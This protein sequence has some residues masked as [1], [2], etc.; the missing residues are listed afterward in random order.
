MPNLKAPSGIEQSQQ[1]KA[2]KRQPGS[3]DETCLACGFPTHPTLPFCFTCTDNERDIAFSRG[4]RHA[5]LAMQG[6]IDRPQVLRVCLACGEPVPACDGSVCV[7]C[8]A[9]CTPHFE[10]HGE[11]R[12]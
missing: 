4:M 9:G 2:A 7:T 12:P 10:P 1:G 8:R 6:K 11:T 3:V 5:I